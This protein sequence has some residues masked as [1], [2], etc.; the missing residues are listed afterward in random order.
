MAVEPEQ[1]TVFVTE[2]HPKVLFWFLSR[3]SH[4][5]AG[6]REFMD[7]VLT[8]AL[9]TSVAPA[10]DHEWDAALSAFHAHI[11]DAFNI[12]KAAFESVAVEN[13]DGSLTIS[14]TA[15]KDAVYAT[16]G[17]QGL[18]GTITCTPLGDCATDVIIGI[19]QAPDWPEISPKAQPVYTD[20]KS[21]QDVSAE[22][23]I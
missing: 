3:A 17:Y 5:Y 23:G 19:F 16:S 21:L 13:D 22:Y 15:L 9:G 18:T 6:R 8:R 4:D 12:W 14:R 11:F 10:N 7:D 20:T 2:T 1:S